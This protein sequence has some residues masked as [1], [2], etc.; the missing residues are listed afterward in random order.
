MDSHEVDEPF[1]DE[2]DDASGGLTRAEVLKRGAAA[3]AAAW[4]VSTL[5]GPGTALA[6]IEA[7]PLTPTF[8]QWIYTN[9]PVI[10]KTVNPTAAMTAPS[11]VRTRGNSRAILFLRRRAPRDL[12]K[13]GRPRPGPAVC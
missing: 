5:F 3:G 2:D 13:P 7:R 4:G 6:G 12:P 8:Y 1:W 11:A 10:P 9:H